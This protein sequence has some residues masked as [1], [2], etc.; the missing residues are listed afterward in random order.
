MVRSPGRGGASDDVVGTG[1]ADGL[2]L[3]RYTGLPSLSKRG[4]PFEAGSGRDSD[5]THRTLT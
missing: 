5:S 3:V 2:C 4:T 1:Q